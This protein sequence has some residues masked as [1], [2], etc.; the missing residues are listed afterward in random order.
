M[1]G[2]EVLLQ[3]QNPMWYLGVVKRPKEERSGDRETG[4]EGDRERK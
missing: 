3:V 2:S 1:Y 4:R